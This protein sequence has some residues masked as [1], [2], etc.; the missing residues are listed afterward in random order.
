MHSGGPGTE[1]N[2][3]PV[4]ALFP[5]QSIGVPAVA[6]TLTNLIPEFT[7]ALDVISREMVGMIPAVR[8]DSA[9][10]R[11]AIG[12]TCYIP[13]TPEA[14][15]ANNTAAVTA[16]D[17]GDQTIANTTI[18]IT[19]SKHVPVRFNGEE[20]RGLSNAGTFGS[21]RSQR[22]YQG[23]RTLVNE[24]EADLWAAA[25]VKASRAY[26]TAGTTPFGTA[27]DMTDFAGVARILDENGAPVSDRQ[28]VLGHAAI[29]NLRGKQSGLF[30]VNEAGSADMLRNGMTDR[31][32]N[33]AIRHS[34]AVGI[35]TK[36]AGASG[37]INNGSG[38]A[39]GQTTLTF[40]TLTVNTTGFKAGDVVTLAADTTNK[41]VVNTGSTATGGDIVIGGPGLLTAIPDN[42]AI[43]IGN[44]YTANLAFDRNAVVL[45]TRMPAMPEGGDAAE[46][47]ITLVDDRSGLAFEIA[48]YKQFLQNVFHVRLAWGCAAIKPEH[49]GTLLG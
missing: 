25:Y 33:F 6:N 26:G 49:I 38:E 47:V 34:D 1:P 37:L 35:H 36:G 29:G 39:I 9:L 41:Y 14:S 10:E 42:N 30:K 7:E 19:K 2:G 28:L 32:Q 31:I 40:D 22:M 44:S 24:I 3:G 15:S 23:M 27:A 11:M 12:Q 4:G 5:S 16:P 8:R 21:I 20:T 18:A 43:T 45:V 13:V 48:L 17:T 46:D